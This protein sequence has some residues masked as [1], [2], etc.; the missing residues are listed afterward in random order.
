[1]TTENETV[2][3]PWP[4]ADLCRYEFQYNMQLILAKVRP[5]FIC[6]FQELPLNRQVPSEIAETPI[7]GQECYY[8][9][10][11]E[12]AHNETFCQ[13]MY[14][15]LGY[16]C[17]L[18]HRSDLTYLV[19]YAFVDKTID[20]IYSKAIWYFAIKRD[21][22][23]DLL[24]GMIQKLKDA[25]EV[26]QIPLVLQVKKGPNGHSNDHGIVAARCP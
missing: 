7:I 12:N 2:S 17:N 18:P 6:W 4:P 5:G 9:C 23:D 8:Y 20:P 24:P 21:D 11:K 14:K 25:Y 22:I 10:L 15:C 13:P 26:L 16:P 1:M 19:L 3:L